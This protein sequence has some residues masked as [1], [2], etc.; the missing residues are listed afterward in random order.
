MM[1]PSPLSPPSYPPYPICYPI[2]PLP[3]MLSAPPP[4]LLKLSDQELTPPTEVPLSVRLKQSMVDNVR[5]DLTE[6]ATARGMTLIAMRRYLMTSPFR[7]LTYREKCLQDRWLGMERTLPLLMTTG[8]SPSP[9]MAYDLSSSPPWRM[10][11]PLT[12]L[13]STPRTTPSPIRKTNRSISPHAPT[14]QAHSPAIPSNMTKSCSPLLKGYKRRMLPPRVARP[15]TTTISGPSRPRRMAPS[16]KSHQAS[17]VTPAGTT[18]HSSSSTK[19]VSST[20]PTLSKSSSAATPSSSLSVKVT[21][22]FMGQPCMPPHITTARSTVP[23]TTRGAS[24]RSKGV[25]KVPAKP[26]GWLGSS[27]TSRSSRR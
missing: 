20:K 8:C 6:E 11:S 2:C 23:D 4:W 18:S 5:R 27:R 26:T 16:M 7:T 25:T 24:R 13:P 12:P 21:L 3:A 1:N 9:T 19:T 17:G 15:S 22:T 10:S 14:R